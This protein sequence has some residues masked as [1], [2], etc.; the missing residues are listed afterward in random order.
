MT[1]KNF[2]HSKLNVS[3]RHCCQC[4]EIVNKKIEIKLC[5]SIEHA[6]NRKQGTRFCSDCGKNLKQ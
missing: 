1:C 2:N 4:G 5:S 6:K 3:V